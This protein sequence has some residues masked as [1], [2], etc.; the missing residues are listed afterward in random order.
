MAAVRAFEKDGIGCTVQ[1][2]GRSACSLDPQKPALF[3]RTTALQQA[4]V[5][6]GPQFSSDVYGALN[7]GMPK[8]AAEKEI[9]ARAPA[10]RC[11]TGTPPCRE[12]MPPNPRHP[13]RRSRQQNLPVGSDRD[14]S[15]LTGKPEVKSRPN[16][17]LRGRE[18]G[19][20]E[21]ISEVSP[22]PTDRQSVDGSVQ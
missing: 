7:P 3:S 11:E 17:Q 18:V 9:P 5:N 6:H 13:I 1:Q 16:S 14:R 10:P 4:L 22:L 20:W 15:R 8:A 12:Q 2:L 19:I 21:S